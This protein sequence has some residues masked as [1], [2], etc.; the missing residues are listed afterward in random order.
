MYAYRDAKARAAVRNEVN[1][2][3]TAVAKS[4]SVWESMLE[5]HIGRCFD[6][7]DGYELDSEGHLRERDAYDTDEYNSD[8]DYVGPDDDEANGETDW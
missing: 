5:A 6:G 8:G 3:I 1:T 4:Y 2:V 7:V